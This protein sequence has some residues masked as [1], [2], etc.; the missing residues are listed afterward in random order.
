MKL[1]LLLLAGALIVPAALRAEEAS[2][3]VHS[4]DGS[5]VTVCLDKDYYQGSLWSPLDGDVHPIYLFVYNGSIDWTENG[6]PVSGE[7]GSVVFTMPVTDITSITFTGLSTLSVGENPAD[8]VMVDVSRGVLTVT[9]VSRKIPMQ[10]CTPAGVKVASASLTADTVIDL[11]S[12]GHG[13]YVVSV[14]SQT[15]KIHVR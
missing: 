4:P 6:E 14:G 10:I 13:I 9:N 5:S 1:N 3:T 2:M 12:Y 8:N 7:N 15:F 11:N